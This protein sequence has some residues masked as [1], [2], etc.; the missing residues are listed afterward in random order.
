MTFD[1]KDGGSLFLGNKASGK[2]RATVPLTKR[3]RKEI[4]AA[5]DA[6]ETEFLVEFAGNPVSNVKRS[7]NKAVRDAGIEDFTIHDLRHTA[8]VWMCGNGTPMDKIS[9]YLSHTRIDIT[10][11]VYAKYQP[12]HLE[13]AAAA[14]EV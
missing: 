14:L 13:D 3:F 1:N 8:A 4:E 11:N 10:R 6:N 2:K 7:F 9:T 12:E 5:I